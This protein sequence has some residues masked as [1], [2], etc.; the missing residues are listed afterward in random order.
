MSPLCS[1]AFS[2]ILLS[3]E[4]SVVNKILT[5]RSD[6]MQIVK[7]RRVFWFPMDA[8]CDSFHHPHQSIIIFPVLLSFL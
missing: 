2:S 4:S 7:T 8:L 1:F 3:S 6:I 5:A